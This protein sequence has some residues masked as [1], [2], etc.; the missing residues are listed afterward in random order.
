MILVCWIVVY[1]LLI[2]F[3]VISYLSSVSSLFYRRFYCEDA[4]SMV[5]DVTT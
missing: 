2:A 5:R 3:I 1:A 4:V